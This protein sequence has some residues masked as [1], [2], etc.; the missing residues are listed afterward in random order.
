MS[1]VSRS[2]SFLAK[3]S[4]S[5]VGVVGLAAMIAAPAS[6]ENASVSG[7]MTR[8]SP[9]GFTTTV[10]GEMVAP[11]GAGFMGP[12]S[13]QGTIPDAGNANLTVNAT[14]TPLPGYGVPSLLEGE[15]LRALSAQ[16]LETE[17]GLDA[18]VAILKAAVGENGL[19]NGAVYPMF[20][21]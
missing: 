7:A 18:Y 19:E 10:S 14:M 2:A 8:T 21:D 11:D 15:V 4:L 12:V 20:M 3:S 9:A 16:N 6:A 5:L 1:L 17:Q 13:V